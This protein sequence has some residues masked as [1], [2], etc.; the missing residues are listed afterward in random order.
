VSGVRP[1]LLVVDDE[2]AVRR[3]LKTGLSADFEVIEARDCAQARA[4]F[5]EHLPSLVLLDVSLPDGEGIDL[6][7]EFRGACGKTVVLMLT[8][9]EELSCASRAIEAGAVEF[10]TK[11]FDFESLRRVVLSRAGLAFGAAPPPAESPWRVSPEK[12]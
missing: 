10:I 11:P 2:P 7:D 12:D 1:K 9:N 5:N 8:A 4:L 6:I 3:V